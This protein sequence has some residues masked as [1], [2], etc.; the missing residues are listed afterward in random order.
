[1]EKYQGVKFNYR[2]IGDSFPSDRRLATLNRWAY[3]F[4]QLGLTPIHADGA[5]GNQ[6]FRT[7]PASF[8]ITR[9]GMTP[10]EQ[11]TAENFS[12][13][14]GFEPSTNT[15]LTEGG[16]IPSSE[17][18]LH[19]A[20]Y[21]VLP[22]INAILHGHSQLLN[23]YAA[24]LDI[25]VTRTFHPYGTLEL[26]ESA[27]ELMDGTLRFFILKDHGF[28]AL[29]EDIDSAGKLTLDFYIRL[30]EILRNL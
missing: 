7:G 11:L 22:D 8:V 16:A 9:S 23:T 27:V 19:D 4:S 2:Q 13:I 24:A 5:Y 26:A 21:K 15:F 20:L 12:H 18:L 29:G 3:L 10:T 1:M 28:V 14:A 25:P 17:S 30:I 6:S